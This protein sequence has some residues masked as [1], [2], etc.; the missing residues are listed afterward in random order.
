[1]W[2]LCFYMHRTDCCGKHLDFLSCLSWTALDTFAQ[3]CWT[4]SSTFINKC[5]WTFEC[6]YLHWNCPLHFALNHIILW[7]IWEGAVR[8]Q[9]TQ[10]H[11]EKLGS[12]Q[13]VEQGKSLTIFFFFFLYLYALLIMPSCVS[14]TVGSR[15]LT[16]PVLITGRRAPERWDASWHPGLILTSINTSRGSPWSDYRREWIRSRNVGKQEGR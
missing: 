7:G 10:P 11:G 14:G 12:E 4:Q 5:H 1:M 13:V 6:I 2:L 8:H 16:V 3:P 15:V 9:T